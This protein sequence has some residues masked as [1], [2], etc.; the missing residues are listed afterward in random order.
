MSTPFF[1]S[2]PGRLI[3]LAAACFTGAAAW[4]LLA[5]NLYAL[6]IG[7]PAGITFAFIG[8]GLGMHDY[9]RQALLS[10]VLLPP[11]LWGFTYLMGEFSTGNHSWGWG[12]A[13]VAVLALLRAAVPGKGAAD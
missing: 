10:M 1:S 13:A 5:G 9:P 12:I 11:A 8:V 6:G 3:L 7:M 4:L 2:N